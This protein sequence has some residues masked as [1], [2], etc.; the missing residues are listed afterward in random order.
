MFLNLAMKVADKVVFSL[1]REKGV[2][3]A[4]KHNGLIEV[5][6]EIGMK[7]LVNRDEIA[8]DYS[9][10]ELH[11]KPIKTNRFYIDKTTPTTI[12][13]PSKSV[14]LHIYSTQVL[15]LK[16]GKLL[17]TQLN[18]LSVAFNNATLSG[19]KELIIIHG[20]GDGILKKAVH[21]FLI[22]NKL[23]KAISEADNK[24]YGKGATKVIL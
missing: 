19:I 23:V 22:A 4:I 5:E 20:V 3:V 14:D 12:K 6:M 7:V 9:T 17:S 2:I 18:L 10:P 16:Q 24:K 13:K 21:E 1:G 8:V 11:Q 15:S